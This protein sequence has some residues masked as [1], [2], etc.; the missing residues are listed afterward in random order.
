MQGEPGHVRLLH[1]DPSED[2]LGVD[3]EDEQDGMSWPRIWRGPY[4]GLL[5]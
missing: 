1:F 2:D 5:H 4:N 3:C